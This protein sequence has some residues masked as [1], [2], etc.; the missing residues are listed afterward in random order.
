M[1]RLGHSPKTPRALGKF[2]IPPCL[3]LRDGV[4]PPYG[5]KH[6]RWATVVRPHNVLRTVVPFTTTV[7]G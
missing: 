2:L 6:L 1:R 7:N 4:V 3:A 5:R